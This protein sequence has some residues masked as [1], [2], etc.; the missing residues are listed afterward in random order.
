MSSITSRVFKHFNVVE[1]YDRAYYD[2][3]HKSRECVDATSELCWKSCRDTARKKK[4]IL[5]GNFQQVLQFRK[6]RVVWNFAAHN[7]SQMWS[8]LRRS[9]IVSNCFEIERDKSNN[10][11]DR[12]SRERAEVI[13]VSIENLAR[14]WDALS[15]IDN[16]ID[17]CKTGSRLRRRFYV[18]FAYNSNGCAKNVRTRVR[19]RRLRFLLRCPYPASSIEK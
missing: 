18:F 7:R 10:R 8:H 14:K 19:L 1:L 12:M 6:F 13:G 3:I 17:R 4:C 11:L 9:R 2:L 16:P 15:N 5:L